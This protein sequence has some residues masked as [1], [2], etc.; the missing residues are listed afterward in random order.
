MN[1]DEIIGLRKEI[2]K[3]AAFPKFLKSFFKK[4]IKTPVIKKVP[5][6]EPSGIRTGAST[7][8]IAGTVGLGGTIYGGM[9]LPQKEKNV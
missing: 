5:K 6:K 1:I 2:E 7:V 9:T 3:S 4:P 8:A